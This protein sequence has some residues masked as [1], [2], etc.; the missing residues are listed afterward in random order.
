MCSKHKNAY[1]LPNQI[2]LIK[3]VEQLPI[4]YTRIYG[5]HTEAKLDDAWSFV[6]LETALPRKFIL[7]ILILFTIVKF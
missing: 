4:I 2:L 1:W 7:I 3:S 6:S 5:P